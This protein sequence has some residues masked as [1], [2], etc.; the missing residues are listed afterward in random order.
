VPRFQGSAAWLEY[1]IHGSE[2]ARA[3]VVL[4]HGLSGSRRWWSRNIPELQKEYRVFVLEL[5]GFAAA[6]AQQTLDLPALGALL[7]EFV[8]D[9]K[10]E[11]P[12]LVGHSMGAHAILHAAAA[13]PNL[14]AGLVLGAASALV[15]RPVLESAAWLIPATLNGALEFAPT[16]ILDGLRAGLLNLWQA[17]NAIT[18]DD[19]STILPQVTTKTLLLHGSKDVLVTLE[20]MRQLERSLTSARLEILPGAGHNLMFD[21]SQEFNK[22][23]LEFLAGLD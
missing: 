5:P 22:F 1:E 11:R 3:S 4:A 17:A 18:H 7:L 20:M 13:R 23:T 21:Q 12:V 9:L 15:N 8:D 19:P 10:L 16:V 2:H 6:K 14:F